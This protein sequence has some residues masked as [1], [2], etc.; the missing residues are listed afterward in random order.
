[1]SGRLSG[2]EGWVPSSLFNRRGKRGKKKAN[3][4]D[5]KK[6]KK[7][8]KPRAGRKSKKETSPAKQKKT[9]NGPALDRG[10]KGRGGETI[11]SYSLHVFFKK[12]ETEPRSGREG[13]ERRQSHHNKHGPGP[14]GVPSTKCPD[15]H[16]SLQPERGGK[17]KGKKGKGTG[18]E[19]G[20]CKPK[21]ISNFE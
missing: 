16:G 21:N 3:M 11:I 1:L 12:R 6:K 10:K 20:K 4:N 7:T 17:G 15:V 9:R 13:K 19:H 8:K 18:K 2:N 14:G 5:S